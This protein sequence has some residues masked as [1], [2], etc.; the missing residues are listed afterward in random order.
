M[1]ATSASE[2]D[3]VT[4]KVLTLEMVMKPE[5]D[6]DE[7]LLDELPVLDD[8]VPLE[9]TLPPTTPLSAVISPAVGAAS[10]QWLTVFC[11]LLT[12]S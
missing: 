12:A 10:V 8:P 7:E 5:L 9:P 11:A 1:F 4:W 6:A 3:P 2:K